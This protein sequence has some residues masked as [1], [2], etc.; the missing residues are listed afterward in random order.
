MWNWELQFPIRVYLNSVFDIKLH[1]YS[2][3]FF[4][5]LIFAL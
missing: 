1:F 3:F 2:Y 5:F 4:S